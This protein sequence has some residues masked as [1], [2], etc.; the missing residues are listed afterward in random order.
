VSFGSSDSDNQADDSSAHSDLAP[1]QLGT[2]PLDE[3]GRDDGASNESV[4]FRLFGPVDQRALALA[5]ADVANRHDVLRTA[6]DRTGR[7][8]LQRAV[9]ASDFGAVLK[10]THIGEAEI[11]QRL[12][13][14]SSQGFNLTAGPLLRAQ[15]FRVRTTESILLIV[16]H[17]SAADPWS[18]GPLLRDLSVAYAARH[19]HMSPGWAPLPQQYAE[20]ALQQQKMLGDMSDP[21]STS[22]RQAQFWITALAGMPDMLQLP[23]DR[24]RPVT[25]SLH[26]GNVGLA[27][28][29][30]LHGRLVKLADECQASLQHV[31]QAGLAAVLTRLG[32]GT[33]LP[34]GMRSAP[35][36]TVARASMRRSDIHVKNGSNTTTVQLMAYLFASS[37]NLVMFLSGLVNNLRL[38]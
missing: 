26:A 17:G 14:A 28:D 4:A 22:W 9:G 11:K 1:A 29:A 20:Y 15:L 37:S 8:L 25:A 38:E 18:L 7:R 31:L 33:D 36:V 5:F 19:A 23:M 12:A 3:V 21:E 10:V 27:V 16:I 13:D 34:I 30:G 2:W 32:A 24:S 35:D 6:I